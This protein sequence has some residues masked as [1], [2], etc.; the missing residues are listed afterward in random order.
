MK[1]TLKS[2]I[3]TSSYFPIVAAHSESHT[4]MH[5]QGGYPKH[6]YQESKYPGHLPA[7]PY[8]ARKNYQTY[9]QEPRPQDRYQHHLQDTLDQT[10]FDG[11]R[12]VTLDQKSFNGHFGQ[13]SF[14][15]TIISFSNKNQRQA[16]P[17]SVPEQERVSSDEQMLMRGISIKD[18]VQTPVSAHTEEEMKMLMRGGLK[19]T[20]NGVQ[21]VDSNIAGNQMVESGDDLR[22]LTPLLQLWHDCQRK[23][24]GDNLTHQDDQDSQVQTSIAQLRQHLS[25][26]SSQSSQSSTS[27]EVPTFCLSLCGARYNE[28]FQEHMDAEDLSLFSSQSSQSSTPSELRTFPPPSDAKHNEMPTERMDAE[29]TLRD[30]TDRL[31]KELSS[32]SDAALEQRAGRS[33]TSHL[34]LALSLSPLDPLSAPLESQGAIEAPHSISLDEIA[35]NLYEKVHQKLRKQ[36]AVSSDVVIPADVKELLQPPTEQPDLRD[37][38][39]PVAHVSRE[40]QIHE[41]QHPPDDELSYLDE[42]LARLDVQ[43]DAALRFRTQQSSEHRTLFQGHL[44][45]YL[46]QQHQQQRKIDPKASAAGAH[47]AAFADVVQ[48]TVAAAEALAVADSE[49]KTRTNMAELLVETNSRK[50][51]TLVRIQ[52]RVRPEVE[53]QMHMQQMACLM[54]PPISLQ[55][56]HL[57]EENTLVALTNATNLPVAEL[58]GNLTLLEDEVRH[59]GTRLGAAQRL[60][61]ARRE[62]VVKLRSERRAL[63]LENEVKSNEQLNAEE[64]RQ[65]K[66]TESCMKQNYINLLTSPEMLFCS[67]PLNSTSLSC[68]EQL[69]RRNLQSRGQTKLNPVTESASWI[70][71]GQSVL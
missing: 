43:F 62:L 42:E 29:D 1:M 33:F 2:N 31:K 53:D 57:S 25:L 34:S 52:D 9:P 35:A 24:V 50:Y 54:Q 38:M 20:Y 3:S 70:C 36:I 48:A 56:I 67:S 69:V 40:W 58:N 61:D 27:S 7:V 30:N 15:D 51:Q 49:A 26:F 65:C 41:K 45:S 22:A 5:N 63:R 32:A 8:A 28:M 60:E 21:D 66:D 19:G 55:N 47:V 23:T 10:S 64:M 46:T 4:L 37:D 12:K 71:I 39:P 6:S 18:E 17:L 16:K 59:S 11:Q 44:S 68:N 14:N 13:A